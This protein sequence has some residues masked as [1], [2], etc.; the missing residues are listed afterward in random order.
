M[1]QAG[2]RCS[3]PTPKHRPSFDALEKAS[4]ACKKLDGRQVP[5]EFS[6]NLPGF[7]LAHSPAIVTE[8]GGL[9]SGVAILI[10]CTFQLLR[11]VVV[12]RAK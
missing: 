10:P 5:H 12:T 2:E 6:P 1:Y 9:S 3:G 7:N 8:N 4:F 11:E